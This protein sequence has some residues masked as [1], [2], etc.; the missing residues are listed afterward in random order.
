MT[1]T[2]AV[3]DRDLRELIKSLEFDRDLHKKLTDTLAE[4]EGRFDMF[5]RASDFGAVVRHRRRQPRLRN[6]DGALIAAAQTQGPLPVK[7]GRFEGGWNWKIKGLNA[8]VINQV[9]Y[10]VDAHKAGEPDGAGL[11][12]VKKWL[13][14]DWS[15][16]ADQMADHIAEHLGQDR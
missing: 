15:D 5:A 14:D 2:L 6:A 13:E 4:S 11:A 9:P 16:V 3:L 7:S 10:A 12:K 8:K 1:E